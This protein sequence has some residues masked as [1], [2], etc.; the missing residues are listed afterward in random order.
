MNVLYRREI[1]SA[2]DPAQ[3]RQQKVAEFSERFSG[4]FDA[5]SK[6]FAQAA[7]RP[8]ETRRR[9]I[10]ALRMLAKK[11]EDRPHKKHSLMPV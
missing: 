3:M 4:P 11:H 7:I 6:Q 9:L 5:L 10:L 2:P 1:D 8:E